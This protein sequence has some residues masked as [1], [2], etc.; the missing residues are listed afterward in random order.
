MYNTPRDLSASEMT[1]IVSGGVLNSTHSPLKLGTIG[2]SLLNLLN[3]LLGS[4]GLDLT[5]HISCFCIIFCIWC[6]WS[7]SQQWLNSL[8]TN[9]STRTLSTSKQL[10]GEDFFGIF[11]YWKTQIRTQPSV[12]HRT[13]GSMIRVARLFWQKVANNKWIAQM[14]V[15]K[16]AS[17]SYILWNFNISL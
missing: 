2:C 16:L 7:V 5:I 3:P 10:S 12:G 14:C 6:M 13:A 17:A 1:Y 8:I 9:I 4:D 15:S 11:S